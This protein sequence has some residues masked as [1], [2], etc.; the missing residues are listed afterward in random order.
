[1]YVSVKNNYKG[2]KRLSPKRQGA[3]K[4]VRTAEGVGAQGYS[5]L[6]GRPWALEERPLGFPPARG[7]P[8]S[9]SGY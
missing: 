3:V 2:L 1:M 9:L 7:H 8:V 4:D 5:I 6:K